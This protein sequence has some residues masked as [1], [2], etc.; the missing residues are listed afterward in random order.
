MRELPVKAKKANRD[1]E[2]YRGRFRRNSCEKPGQGLS[3]GE[4]KTVPRLR[5]NF[6][7]FRVNQVAELLGRL[8]V[9]HPFG[10]HLYALTGLGIPAYA[11]VPL[12]DPER[13]EAAYLNLVAA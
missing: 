7:F 3:S 13:S 9:R 1:T 11:R 12:P 4:G 2:R 6:G 10:R 8:E 5:R